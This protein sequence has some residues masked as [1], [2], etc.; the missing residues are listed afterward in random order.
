[1]T[2]PHPYGSDRCPIAPKDCPN[3]DTCDGCLEFMNTC[4]L[5]LEAGHMDAAGAWNEGHAGETLCNSCFEKLGE[6]P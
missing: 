6:K 3:D 2:H 1:M 4:D 5:C